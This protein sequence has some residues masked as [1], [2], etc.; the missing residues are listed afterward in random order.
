MSSKYVTINH[1]PCWI[2]FICSI[3][4]PVLFSSTY[5]AC[6]NFRLITNSK[7]ILNRV[8]HYGHS[9][10]IFGAEQMQTQTVRLKIKKL[11]ITA[12]R[13]VCA[14]V[15]VCVCSIWFS[16]LTFESLPVTRCTN[17]FNIQ[18]L[19]ALPTLHLCVLYLSENKQRL[20]PLTA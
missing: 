6:A 12:T 13:F 5:N 7:K 9:A 15:R 4:F 1:E 10:W 19:Y 20:V 11:S 17:R 14:C 3:T 8:A 16:E 18:Q 2:L